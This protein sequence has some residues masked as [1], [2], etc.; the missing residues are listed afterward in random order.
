MVMMLITGTMIGGV[1]VVLAHVLT[2]YAARYSLILVWP[3][4]MALFLGVGLSLGARM[5]GCSPC[6]SR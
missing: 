2:V 6:A 1:G 3:I 5:G 4:V